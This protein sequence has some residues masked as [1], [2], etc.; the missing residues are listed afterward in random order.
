MTTPANPPPTP[1]FGARLGQAIRIFLRTL[2]RLLL[3]LLVFVL[4]G[5]AIYYG[6]PLAY[7][8]FIEP[9]QNNTFHIQSLQTSQA[10]ENG[11]VS[12]T[13]TSAQNRLGTLEAQHAADS[14]TMATLQAHVDNLDSEA[15]DAANQI[16]AST[17]RLD[18]LNSSIEQISIEMSAMTTTINTDETTLQGLVGKIQAGDPAV[19]SL[20]QELQ[21]LKGMELITRSRLFLGQNNP[22]L[23]QQD[24]QAAYDLLNELQN[25]VPPYQTVAVAAV[26]QRLKLA[27]V[28]LPGTPVLAAD[29]LEIA[30]Q[31]LVRG[32][33]E[34]TP[35][36]A[37]A[38]LV[39]ASPV[40]TTTITNT[41]TMT[42]TPSATFTPVAT[43]TPLSGST[44]IPASVTP[45]P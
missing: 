28:D 33:P 27:L 4:I 30:W 6:V 3:I 16:K 5:L 37:G 42:V 34:K 41:I 32:L 23:A 29:D 43:L 22:G 25:Q 18:A 12:Q 15:G 36:A 1:G 7:S 39:T 14:Q 11:Q 26:V 20:E 9:V 38:N 24:V 44:V 17:E 13:L 35:E 8:R 31:L 10:Q 2:A 21:L 45:T 40:V 19:K